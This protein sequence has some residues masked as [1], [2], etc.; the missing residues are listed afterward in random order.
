MGAKARGATAPNG[1]PSCHRASHSR[2]G[3]LKKKSQ[4]QARGLRPQVVHMALSRQCLFCRW[5]TGPPPPRLS[6]FFFSVCLFLLF[7][8]FWVGFS[9]FWP[10]QVRRCTWRTGRGP[11]HLPGTPPSPHSPALQAPPFLRRRY[12]VFSLALSAALASISTSR[13]S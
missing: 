1:A 5:H 2:R 8:A 3:P 10:G 7:A 12:T 4:S 13:H 6:A 9:C 11:C